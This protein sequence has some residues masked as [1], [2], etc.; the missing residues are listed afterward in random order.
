LVE[1]SARQADVAASFAQ[2]RDTTAT[3]WWRWFHYSNDTNDAVIVFYTK[4]IYSW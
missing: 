3:Q 1:V 2:L 4:S